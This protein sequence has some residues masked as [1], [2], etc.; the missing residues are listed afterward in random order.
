MLFLTTYKQSSV[1]VRIRTPTWN[2]NKSVDF[3]V[4]ISNSVSTEIDLPI[5]LRHTSHTIEHFTVLLTSVDEFVVFAMNYKKFSA[6][7][8][9]VYPLPVLGTTYTAASDQSNSE[10]GSN[11]LIG[12]AAHVATEIFIKLPISSGAQFNGYS[13]GKGTTLSVVLEPYQSFQISGFGETDDLTGTL[14]TGNVSFAGM[15]SQLGKI[16]RYSSVFNIILDMFCP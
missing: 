3:T 5:E 8:F 1:T 10:I 11:S 14:L 12:G 2:S 9:V 4:E 6:D 16:N 7:A 15:D 13:Y